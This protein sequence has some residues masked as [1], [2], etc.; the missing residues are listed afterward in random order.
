L[1]RVN[2]VV[3]QD[4]DKGFM[5]SATITHKEEDGTDTKEDIVL[6]TTI[7]DSPRY[8][9]GLSALSNLFREHKILKFSVVMANDK[10]ATT[11]RPR[12]KK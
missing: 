12:K 4:L 6:N 2:V 9:K 1:V 7:G 8:F 10:I 11:E 5:V 3:S